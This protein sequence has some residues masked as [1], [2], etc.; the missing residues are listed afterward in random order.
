MERWSYECFIRDVGEGGKGREWKG[1][2]GLE[3]VLLGRREGEYRERGGGCMRW[4]ER[5]KRVKVKKEVIE[6]K[7]GS[8]VEESEGINL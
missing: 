8:R 4:N 3:G 5:K 6:M 7:K 1:W 2:P